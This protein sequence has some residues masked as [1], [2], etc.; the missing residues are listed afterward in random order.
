VVVASGA[1]EPHHPAWY[2]NL[3]ADPDVL[4]QVGAEEFAG[5]EH[6]TG[7]RATLSVTPFAEP[8]RRIRAEVEREAARI[9]ADLGRPL[10]LAWVTPG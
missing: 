10:D 6:R 3:R 1:G 2:L 4:V 7:G 5:E 8:T 9:A